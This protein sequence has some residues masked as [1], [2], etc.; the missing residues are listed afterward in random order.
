M[1]NRKQK[2]NPTTTNQ[3]KVVKGGNRQAPITTIE[4]AQRLSLADCRVIMNKGEAE[5]S[6]AELIKLRDYLYQLAAIA[7]EQLELGKEEAK[8][9]SL[10]IHKNNTDEKSHYLRTG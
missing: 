4:E 3:F 2:A 9:I 5:Y 7:T 8:I 10:H 6:D 1:K